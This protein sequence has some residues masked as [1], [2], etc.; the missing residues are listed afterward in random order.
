MDGIWPPVSRSDRIIEARHKICHWQSRRRAIRWQT[1][2]LCIWGQQELSSSS[3]RRGFIN[4]GGKCQQQSS[5]S[6]WQSLND[7]GLRSIKELHCFAQPANPARGFIHFLVSGCIDCR[8]WV[9][10]C[11]YTVHVWHLKF[12]QLFDDL[13]HENHIFSESISSRGAPLTT[14][15]TWPPGPPWLAW[16]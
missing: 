14:L 16:S 3:A 2:P 6:W 4:N 13:G 8:F 5:G 15:T 10:V 12:S 11:V 7:L 1:G 9:F